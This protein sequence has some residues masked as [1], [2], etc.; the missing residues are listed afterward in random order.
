MS[1]FASH[2]KS[3]PIPLPTDPG[4]TVV[5][6]K[7]TG[8][9]VEQ[10]QAEHARGIAAGRGWANRFRRLIEKGIATDAQVLS[11]LAD[12]LIGYDRRSLVDAGLIAWSYMEDGK[13]K[14]LTA[15][16]KADIDDETSEFI[17]TEVLR[18][19]KPS[20]FLSVEEVAAAR[21]NGSGSS[22]AD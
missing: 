14:P 5:V 15:E 7:L 17:A 2:T 8:I 13:P 22:R 6:R 16:S 10:A 19:T 9:E 11:A 21:K 20:L 18:L 12:P 3:Q 4:Q 1:I